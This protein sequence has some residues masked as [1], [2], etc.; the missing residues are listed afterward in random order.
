MIRGA[1]TGAWDPDAAMS[2]PSEATTVVGSTRG[3]GGREARQKQS[4][5]EADHAG[6][7]EGIRL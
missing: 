3:S 6:E 4:C 2:G 5:G 1:G 7:R